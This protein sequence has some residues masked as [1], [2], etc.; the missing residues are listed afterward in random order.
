MRNFNA[1]FKGGLSRAK[2]I[3]LVAVAVSIGVAMIVLIVV[4]SFGATANAV[5]FGFIDRDSS[6]ATSDFA[7]YLETDMGIELVAS[8]NVDEMNTELVEKKIS[9]IIEIPAGF[10]ASLLTGKPDPVLLTFMDD[11]AN[12]AFMKGYIESYMQSIGVAS[13]ASGGDAALF[14]SILAKAEVERISVSAIEKD[15]ELLKIQAD[16]EGLHLL[17]SFFS[18]FSFL[19]SISIATMLFTDRMEGTYRRIKAGRVTSFEYVSSVAAI[20]ALM[21]LLI[22]APAVAMYALSGSDPGMPVPAIIGALAAL[23][24]FVI[25]F[26]LLIGLIM[27]SHGGII[28]VIV[29]VTTITSFLSGAWFPINMA[30]DFFRM[31]GKITPQYWFFEAIG[32]WQTGSASPAGPIL[33][34]L[35]VAILCFVF[36]GV[37]F[38]SNRSLAR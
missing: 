5:R 31:L 35:L 8:D 21:M 2:G 32:A 20:G 26:G 4:N 33:I 27:P 11:Y 9:G 10:E 12:E 24:M 37:Q 22:G 7:H 13:V 16:K 18:M 23:S 17:L 1:L 15:K 3:L 25:S 19:M 14:E 30:P 38:T 29:A 6:A 28:A 36:A 34:V